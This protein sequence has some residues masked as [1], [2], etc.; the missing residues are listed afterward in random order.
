MYNE[1]SSIKTTTFRINKKN[2]ESVSLT[3]ELAV[4]LGD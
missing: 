3:L 1:A 2:S 4:G